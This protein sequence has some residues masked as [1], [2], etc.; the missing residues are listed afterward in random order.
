M[1]DPRQPI[2]DRGEPLGPRVDSELVTICLAYAERLDGDGDPAP[3]VREGYRLAVR[4]GG[5]GSP[6]ATAVAEAVLAGSADEVARVLCDVVAREGCAAEHECVAIATS[7]WSAGE[8]DVA[9]CPRPTTCAS[10]VLVALV[11]G[12][13]QRIHALEDRSSVRRAQ[14]LY[15]LLVTDEHPERDDRAL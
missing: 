10:D 2:D 5:P 11:L 3:F 9:P 12:L 7:G 13:V 4:P 1:A 15:D 8:L 6:L 14:L